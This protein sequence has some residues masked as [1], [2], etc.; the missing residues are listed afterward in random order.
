MP[1]FIVLS[2]RRTLLKKT[3]LIGLINL[4]KVLFFC[5][6]ILNLFFEFLRKNK[7]ALAH[8]VSLWCAGAVSAPCRPFSPLSVSFD[9]AHVE[10]ILDSVA[11]DQ[12]TDSHAKW[13][14][15]LS[16]SFTSLHKLTKRLTA[17]DLFFFW[18]YNIFH[19]LVTLRRRHHLI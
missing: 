7:R 15:S 3:R 16:F 9:F 10:P 11:A 12:P 4:R 8:C 17:R 5:C 2:I 18:I 14:S 6:N 19:T 1:P 13:L